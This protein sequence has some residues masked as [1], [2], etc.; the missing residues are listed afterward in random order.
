MIFG[1]I[2][3]F[4]SIQR[5]VACIYLKQQTCLITFTCMSRQNLSFNSIVCRSVRCLSYLF[6]ICI[7]T[8][9]TRFHS[10]TQRSAHIH[11]MLS[12][13]CPPSFAIAIVFNFAHIYCTQL[14]IALDPHNSFSSHSALSQFP[15]TL[16]HWRRHRR[17]RLNATFLSNCTRNIFSQRAPTSKHMRMTP[18]YHS[19]LNHPPFHRRQNPIDSIYLYI[20][21]R[22]LPYQLRFFCVGIPFYWRKTKK[23]P[24]YFH[25]KT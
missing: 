6:L 21:T 10:S 18:F 3:P 5:C 2:M 4:Y 24:N 19:I 1:P 22:S 13:C 23:I 16:N 14:R 11:I 8:P 9:P 20:W 17:S 12:P 7:H 25:K 15:P